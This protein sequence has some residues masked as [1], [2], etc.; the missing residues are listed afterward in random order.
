MTFF[1]FAKIKILC[2]DKDVK[3]GFSKTWTMINMLVSMLSMILI[4]FLMSKDS[5]SGY[6]YWE[7]F[8]LLALPTFGIGA[9]LTTIF[10]FFDKFCC[11]CSESLKGEEQI[12]LFDPNKPESF[13]VWKD[14]KVLDYDKYMKQESLESNFSSIE[15]NYKRQNT[16]ESEVSTLCRQDTVDSDVE[17]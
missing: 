3:I 7:E 5:K 2:G 12:M 15:D 13:L 9:I 1:T 8:L 14:G 6:E 11:F 10:L 17:N 4:C 16:S